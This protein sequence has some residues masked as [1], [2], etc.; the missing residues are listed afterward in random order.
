MS[1]RSHVLSYPCPNRRFLGLKLLHHLIPVVF[2]VLGS[3][4]IYLAGRCQ[5]QNPNLT[6]MYL[7]WAVFL[8]A[9]LTAYALFSNDLWR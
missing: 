9:G 6:R 8:M 3:V 4:S 7:W 2:L 5:T 1:R